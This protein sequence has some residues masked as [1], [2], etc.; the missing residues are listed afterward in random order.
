MP[1]Y[2]G[3]GMSW[4]RMTKLMIVGLLNGEPTPFDGQWV[5]E[6]DPTRRGADPLGKPMIAHLVTTT[7]PFNAKEFATI[8]EAE[9]CWRQAF[10]LRGD[11]RPNRPLTAF[12]VEIQEFGKTVGRAHDPWNR[13][14]RGALTFV[15]EFPL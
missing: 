2:Y 7:D 4:A 12:V 6:Y 14:E 10:G 11:G 13:P 5:V 9:N 8:M 15:A 1:R 3:P